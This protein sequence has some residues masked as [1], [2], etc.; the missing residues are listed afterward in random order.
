MRILDR[1]VLRNFLEP[2]FLCFGAFLGILLIFDLNDN[3]SDFL[4]A[5]GKL[6]QI[7]LYYLHQLPRFVLLSMP[8]GLLLGL[9]YCLSKMSRS[10]EIISILS[11]GRSIVRLIMPLL[12][13]GVVATGVC[14]ALN[15]EM[16][17]RADGIRKADM[18]RITKGDKKAASLNYIESQLAK[19]RMTNRI[20]FVRKI[21]LDEVN[22]LWDAH[23]TQLDANSQPITRWAAH[24][25][26][27]NPAESKWQLHLGRKLNFDAEGSIIEPI[28]DWTHETSA[29]ITRTMPGW[30]ETP[31]RI[32]SAT[33]EADQLTVPELH[34]YLRYN[35][36]FPEAQLAAFRTNL[37]NRWAVPFSC[38]AVCFL[39][40]PLGIVF[41]RRAV[42]AS[43]ASTIFIFFGYLF[44]MFLLLALGKGGHLTPIL[45]G[46]LPNIFLLL[47]G[48]TFLYLRSTNRDL[49]SLTFW[50]K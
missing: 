8:L 29:R 33:M 42:L 25:A 13:C 10:N 32:L 7:G 4:E 3:I 39:A 36:D 5:H 46:W 40:A 9:L 17:P 23:I 11:S 47:T 2:F 49:P 38:L 27:Y 45:A 18:E 22:N 15:Y 43:V 6:Q 48:L 44:L 26:I 37:E 34:D 19:D 35:A 50:K 41:S 28:E 16:A 1:Y 20:W 12:A 31:W 30:S 21:R 24:H 14:L